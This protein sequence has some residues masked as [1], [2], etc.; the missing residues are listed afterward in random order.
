[1]L[2]TII[3]NGDGDKKKMSL[4]QRNG[5]NAIPVLTEPLRHG[6][7]IGKAFLNDTLGADMNQNITFGGTPE[8]IHDGGDNAGWTGAAG[9]G[10]WDFADT[11]DPQADSAHV[12]ITLASNNDIATFNDGGEIDMSNY[13][14]ITGQVQLVSYNANHDIIFQAQNNGSN[15]GISIILDDYIDTGVVGSYQSF[16]IPKADMSLEGETIDELDIII[17]KGS[18]AR[19]TIYFDSI[20]IEETGAPATFRVTPTPGKKLHMS[21]LIVTIADVGTGG[22]AR[23][24]NKMGALSTLSNGVCI[25]S[26]NK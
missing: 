5:W 6:G 9:Q 10:S 3:T 12:S 26:N 15:V 17:S 13:S 23:A 11:T 24:Y 1:M 25:E 4:V 22:T 2:H 8:L 20:Q 18:G 14:A 7:A 19:P 16:V 21:K